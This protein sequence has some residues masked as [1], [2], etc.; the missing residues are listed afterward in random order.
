MKQS[1]GKKLGFNVLARAYELFNFPFVGL[2]AQITRE[3]SLREVSDT[4]PLR[5]AQRELGIKGW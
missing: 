4:T 5:E 2:A 3:V 1:K